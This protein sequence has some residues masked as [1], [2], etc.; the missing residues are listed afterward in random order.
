MIIKQ[1][2]CK[3]SDIIHEYL[4]TKLKFTKNREYVTSENDFIS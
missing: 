1:K 3:Y 4:S 2:G